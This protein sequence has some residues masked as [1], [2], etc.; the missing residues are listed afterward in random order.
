M[1]KLTVK[2]PSFE[3]VTAGATATLRLPIGRTYEKLVIAYS[4]V[5]LAQMKEIRLIG[6][7]KTLRRYVGAAL[8]DVINQFDRQN[9]ADGLLTLHLGRPGLLT[10][11][12]REETLLGTG[13]APTEQV[14]VTLTTLQLEIDIDA[15]ASGP[16]LSAKAVQSSPRPLDKVL[17]VRRFGYAPS[18]AGEFEISDLP[19]G[20]LINR[21]VFESSKIDAIRIERDNRVIFE[22]TKAENEDLQ[23]NGVRD[24]QTGYFVYDPTEEGYGS[25]PL[26]TAGVQDLRFILTMSGADQVPVN[27]EYIGRMER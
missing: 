20:D 10:R 12:A 19:R 9:A 27:V 3:G 23:S 4:G 26:V 17:K 15:A 8:V 11:P 13:I 16:T 1:P 5:T 22:R 18:A 14:P 21:I 7:G 2:M 6:N 25:E 24:P